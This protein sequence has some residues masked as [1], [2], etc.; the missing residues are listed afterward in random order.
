VGLENEAEDDAF[1]DNNNVNG[2]VGAGSLLAAGDAHVHNNDIEG[3]GSSASNGSVVGSG[4]ID[5]SVDNSERTRIDVEHEEETE[6][7]V[8][9]DIDDSNVLSPDAEIED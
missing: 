8:D 3:N 1:S 5:N 7:D 9:V 2:D 6:I 4:S